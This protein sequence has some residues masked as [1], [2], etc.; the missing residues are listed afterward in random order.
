MFYERVSGDACADLDTR[1][2]PHQRMVA[3]ITQAQAQKE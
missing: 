2:A 3:D 1:P